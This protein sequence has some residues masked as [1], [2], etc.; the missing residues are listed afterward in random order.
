MHY[1]SDGYFGPELALD[2]VVALPKDGAGDTPKQNG[3]P[4]AKLYRE[5]NFAGDVEWQGGAGFSNSPSA[6]SYS[7]ELP[8]GWSARTWRAD[9]RQE[10]GQ[11]AVRCWS[12]PVPNLQD[13][14][15]HLAVQS[16]EVYDRNVCPVGPPPSASGA[17]KFFAKADFHEQL[18]SLSA[19]THDVEQRN[20]FSI[21]MPDG[22]SVRLFDTGGRNRCFNQDVHNLQDHEDWWNRTARGCNGV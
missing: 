16:I 10:S 13:H 17:V 21:D 4:V 2:I 7:L 11:D 12:A 19:G 20:Y 5:A 8:S 1:S 22:W 15:W 6:Q 14:G 9:D 18:L 3:G